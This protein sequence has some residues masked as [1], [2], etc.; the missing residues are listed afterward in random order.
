MIIN[1]LIGLLRVLIK[2]QSDDSVYTD[3]AIYTLLMTAR[4]KI[5][6]DKYE[7]EKLVPYMNWQ[8]ITLPLIV[9]PYVNCDC[10]K[11]GCNVVKS[12]QRIPSVV[13]SN[14]GSPFIRVKLFNGEQLSYV[15]PE[16]QRTNFESETLY[17]QIA[18]YIE[19]NKLILWNTLDIKAVMVEGVFSDPMQ[20]VNYNI[21]DDSG[22]SYNSPCF[23]PTI[24]EFPLE[25]SLIDIVIA[26][27]LN[28]LF[29]TLSIPD[30]KIND[31]EV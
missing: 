26:N 18:Y 25:E 24:M 8:T 1:K 23:D 31:S 13:V 4:T 29:P 7:Y 30:D 10:V 9:E 27:V 5:L 17:D 3:E 14:A 15:K 20:L 6:A 21:C 16:R 22:T 12:R 2:Q 11:I 19:N 28:K